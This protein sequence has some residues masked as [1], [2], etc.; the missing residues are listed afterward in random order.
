MKEKKI[1][2]PNRFEPRFWE[3]GD[4]RF[5]TIKEIRRRYLVLRDHA[6]GEQSAQRDILV[7]RVAFLCTVL[8]TQEVK[9]FEDGEFDLDAYARAVN[10]LRSIIG[11]LGLEKRVKK[12]QSLKDYLGK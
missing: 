8:E 7:Q 12:A 4:G 11:T 1:K 3:D 10:S 5:A 2:L 9:A 6:G